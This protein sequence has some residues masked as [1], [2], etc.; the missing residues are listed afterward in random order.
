LFEA[1]FKSFFPKLNFNAVVKFY[2]F[3]PFCGISA[4]STAVS[5]LIYHGVAEIMLRELLFSTNE[6]KNLL[7]DTVAWCLRTEAEPNLRSNKS[8]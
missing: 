6:E 3:L 7:K 8:S 2:I 1:V 4:Q 5:M